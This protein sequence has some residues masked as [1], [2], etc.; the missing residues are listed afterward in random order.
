MTY[1]GYTIIRELVSIQGEYIF[2]A[3]TKDGK[4]VAAAGTKEKLYD[5]LDKIGDC[6][7]E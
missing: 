1:R 5:E 7:D 4:L 6:R 3:Y 2:E